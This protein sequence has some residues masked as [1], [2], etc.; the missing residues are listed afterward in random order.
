MQ[1]AFNVGSIPGLATPNQIEKLE[2]IG[3]DVQSIAMDM[4]PVDTGYLQSS[5]NYYVD[6][7][8]L[9]LQADAD[10]TSFVEYGTYKM[11]AQPFLEPAIAQVQGEIMDLQQLDVKD[12]VKGLLGIGVTMALLKGSEKEG[13]VESFFEEQG[14]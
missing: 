9:I 5:I 6:G 12:I 2:E 13:E 1:L 14:L 11:G 3:A 10:Y 7:Q 8:S 4:C